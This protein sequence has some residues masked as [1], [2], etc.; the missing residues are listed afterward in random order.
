MNELSLRA[1]FLRAYHMERAAQHL[2]LERRNS[3]AASREN[4]AAN[5]N[6]SQE[7]SAVRMQFEAAH[8]PSEEHVSDHPGD[9]NNS[10]QQ[11]EGEEEEDAGLL[12]RAQETAAEAREAARRN[13]EGG[14]EKGG[15]K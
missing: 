13:E 4:D 6:T 12:Q 1:A 5:N 8:L 2:D 10:Q 11:Q 15:E 3:V 9:S 14:G 7:R